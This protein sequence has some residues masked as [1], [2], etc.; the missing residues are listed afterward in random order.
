MVNIYAVA[1]MSEKI[2]DIEATRMRNKAGKR[3]GCSSWIDSNKKVHECSSSWC[4]EQRD[5][6]EAK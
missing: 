5:G 2:K 3:P 4:C 1:G 6:L